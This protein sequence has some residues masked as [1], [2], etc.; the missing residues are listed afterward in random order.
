MSEQKLHNPKAGDLLISEPFLQDENFVRSVV[1]LC[2][3]SDEGSFGLII[4]KPSILKLGELVEALD[5]LDSELF[6]GG[7]VEQNTL[8]FIYVGDKVLDGS[9][10]LGEKVWWGGDYDSLIE[11]LKLGLLDPDSVR[12]FIGYSGW[13]SEQLEDELSDE[14]WIICSEK[15]DEQTFSFTPEELWKSLLKNMGGEFKV[16]ANYP[17]DPRLN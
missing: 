3:H 11:K 2:E 7:P 13:G 17:L 1:L 8:H 6:V 15:L 9:L 4:N 10:S 12:F 5:F 14:T 16:I